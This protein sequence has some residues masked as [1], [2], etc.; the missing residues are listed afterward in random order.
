M[1]ILANPMSLIGSF[2]CVFWYAVY[3][4]AIFFIFISRILDFR[5]KQSAHLSIYLTQARIQSS[6][7]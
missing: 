5:K 7:L 2:G 6:K 1:R 4:L 3:A